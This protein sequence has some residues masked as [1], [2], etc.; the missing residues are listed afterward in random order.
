MLGSLAGLVLR[1]L[2]SWMERRG[3][4]KEARLEAE[5]TRLAKAAEA[6]VS[7]DVEAQRQRRHTLLDEVLAFV[8]LA[9][10][11]AGFWPDPDVQTA[12]AQGWQSL[13]LAPWW[14][15]ALIL[16]VYAATFGLRWLFQG[17][18]RLTGRGDGNASQ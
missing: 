7:Y 15:Q 4:L 3:R 11:V 16:G 13:A 2:T 5:I 8:L 17:R 10:F 1:P 6:E 12:I 14:Y 9:P 18:Y